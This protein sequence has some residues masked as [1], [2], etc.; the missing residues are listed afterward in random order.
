MGHD[1][2]IYESPGLSSGEMPIARTRL[3][4]EWNLGAPSKGFRFESSAAQAT[5][6]HIPRV[7]VTVTTAST[8]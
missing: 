1:C 7:P 6:L 2:R 4:R 5:N 3:G 8:G